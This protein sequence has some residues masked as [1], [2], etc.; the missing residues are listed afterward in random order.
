M[1]SVIMFL[2]LVDKPWE[3]HDG[4]RNLV[5]KLHAKILEKWS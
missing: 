3:V 5:K 2:C 1:Q 4:R